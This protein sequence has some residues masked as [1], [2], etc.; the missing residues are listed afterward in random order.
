MESGRESISR[1]DMFLNVMCV[2]YHG[3]SSPEKPHVYSTMR[4]ATTVNK[5]NN[6]DAHHLTISPVVEKRA[7][8][9]GGGKDEMCLRGYT[10]SC[11]ASRAF[12]SARWTA[13]LVP[14]M[15]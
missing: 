10:R 4:I 15:S 13:T 6:Y 5:H 14:F 8:T 2:M 9:G 12:V 1:K 7:R 3:L 11:R